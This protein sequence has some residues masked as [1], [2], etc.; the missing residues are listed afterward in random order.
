[1]ALDPKQPVR[2]KKDIIT[3]GGNSFAARESPYAPGEIPSD[4]LTEEYCTQKGVQFHPLPDATPDTIKLTPTSTDQTLALKEGELKVDGEDSK[5]NI[6]FASPEKI[7]AFIDGAGSKTVE[8]LDSQ[9][10]EK[11][12]ASIE[13]LEERCPLPKISGKTWSTYKDVITF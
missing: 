1:M 2:V 6:N 12:F 7:A 9:R 5:I 11:P 10:Q 8:K 13:D 4:F 3:P